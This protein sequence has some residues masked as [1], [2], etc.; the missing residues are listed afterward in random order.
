MKVAV[1]C[2]PQ[3]SWMFGQRASSHTVVSRLA[4][5]RRRTSPNASLA[6]G[7][8]RSQGGLRRYVVPAGFEAGVEAG[9]AGVEVVV[10]AAMTDRL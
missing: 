10:C 7:R 5:I 9:A 4:R 3:H 6:T 8:V 1:R 2:T